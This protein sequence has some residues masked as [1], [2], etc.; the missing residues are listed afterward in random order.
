VDQLDRFI[1]P[2]EEF[3]FHLFEF[4]RTK[5]VIARIDLVAKCLSDLADAERNFLPGSVEDI[6][7][8]HED[9]LRGFGTQIGSIVIRLDRADVGPEHQV[10]HP[11][12]G[13]I[14]SAA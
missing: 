10:E 4:A 1:G 7:E 14:A 13:K 9:R 6:F 3:K 12:F 2:D 5:R 8:L 11:R